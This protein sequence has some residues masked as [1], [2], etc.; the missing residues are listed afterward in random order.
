MIKENSHQKEEDTDKKANYD[1]FRP[2]FKMSKIKKIDELNPGKV[3]DDEAVSQNHKWKRML[4][5][6]LMLKKG[7]KI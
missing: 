1:K 4:I 7:S 5:Q 6:Y 3:N 2:K